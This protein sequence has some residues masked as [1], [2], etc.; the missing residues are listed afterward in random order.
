MFT[1]RTIGLW[2]VV[3]A[4]V[5]TTAAGGTAFAAGQS[6]NATSPSQLLPKSIRSSGVL[7]VATDPRFPPNTFYDTDGKTIIGINPDIAAAMARVLH[8]KLKLVPTSFAA[9]I[10]G[11]Q[12]GKYDIAMSGISDT[13]VREKKV[14]FVDYANNGQSFIVPVGNPGKIEKPE[15]ICGKSL[16]LVEGTISVSIAKKQSE[17]CVSGGKKAVNIMLFP[18]APQAVL[19]LQTG[20]A[21]AN[22]ANHNKGVLIA[23]KSHGKL[24][25]TNYIFDSSYEGIALAKGQPELLKALH[26]ALTELWGN[27]EYHAIMKKWGSEATAIN[28]PVING[29]TTVKK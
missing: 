9:L 18:S 6:A 29:T 24:E 8:L 23:K 10:P 20:R 12:S 4:T 21:Q 7:T 28:A 25:V 3:A 22:I 14:D 17:L 26:G 11:L 16:A 15:D 27:G 13:A 5:A 19:Q 1:R 2:L